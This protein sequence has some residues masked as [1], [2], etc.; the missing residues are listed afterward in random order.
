MTTISVLHT[1]NQSKTKEKQV[2]E[3]SGFVLAPLQLLVITCPD[4]SGRL[5]NDRVEGTLK[6]AKNI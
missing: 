5:N 2:Q 4:L 6:K 1:K 3:N